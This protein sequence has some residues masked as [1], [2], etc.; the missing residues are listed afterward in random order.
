VPKKRRYV[1]ESLY[2]HYDH[3]HYG[4]HLDVTRQIIEEK[5]PEYLSAFDDVMK[6]TYGH[7]FN[8]FIMEKKL[9]DEYCEWL[10]GILFEL[11]ARLGEK[12]YSYFQGRFYGRVSEIIFNVWLAKRSE[13]IK[14][15]PYIHMEKIDWRKKGTAF[16]RAKFGNKKYE[17]SF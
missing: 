17:G 10:F 14:E 12:E 15:I 2:S 3:T 9:A 4:E 11:E 5:Y 1:I 7:M 16:L 8:M 13:P 6:Q